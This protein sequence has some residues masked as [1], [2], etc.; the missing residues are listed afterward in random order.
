MYGN[1]I[2]ISRFKNSKIRFFICQ[3]KAG[4]QHCSRMTTVAVAGIMV[5][6]AC[7]LKI[8]EADKGIADDSAFDYCAEIGCFVERQDDCYVPISNTRCYCDDFCY[9]NRTGSEDCCPDFMSF[10]KGM[11]T[12]RPDPTTLPRKNGK[13]EWF[14]P[15][16]DASEHY[17]FSLSRHTRNTPIVKFR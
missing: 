2:S 9:L 14:S 7:A 17:I 10:C 13:H 15:Y 11:T 12:T 8:V 16:K 6:L 4:H 3:M 5:T 1:E